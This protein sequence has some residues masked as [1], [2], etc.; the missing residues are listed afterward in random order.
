MRLSLEW[1]VRGAV[2]GQAEARILAPVGCADHNGR[3]IRCQ[4]LVLMLEGWVS[5]AQVPLNHFSERVRPWPDPPV[6][7]IGRSHP[8]KRQLFLKP[9]IVF[10]SSF[11]VF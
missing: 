6:G 3:F 11:M 8:L 2:V 10:S 9:K 1:I 5:L 4:L 7:E